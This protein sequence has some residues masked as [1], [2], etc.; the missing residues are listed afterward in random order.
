MGDSLELFSINLKQELF[1]KRF[2]LKQAKAAIEK[3]GGESTL[4]HLPVNEKIWTSLLSKQLFI[5]QRSD[6]IG[7]VL[8]F[9]EKFH[10]LKFTNSQ[11]TEDSLEQIIKEYKSIINNLKVLNTLF[12]QRID[13]ASIDD[14]DSIISEQSSSKKNA[15]LH[16][17]LESFIANFLTVDLS[18][19]MELNEE[20]SSRILNLIERLIA[21]DHTLKLSDFEPDCLGLYRLLVNS[22]LIIKIKINNNED[23]FFLRL[24][25][26]N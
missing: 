17:I 23:D 22:C 6:P 10:Q 12:L 15:K 1:N 14:R 2:F 18:G 11:I 13:D 20:N 16:S 25:D 3:L 5:P 4:E 21:G 19:P 26:L 7:L 9:N 8:L 24:H